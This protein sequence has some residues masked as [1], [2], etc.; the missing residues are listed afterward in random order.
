MTRPPP[1]SSTTATIEPRTPYGP[2]VTPLGP[3]Y[4]HRRTPGIT[5][6]RPS[7]TGTPSCSVTYRES[8]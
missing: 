5:S 2:V 6:P 3:A 7:V 8:G 4:T 1:G